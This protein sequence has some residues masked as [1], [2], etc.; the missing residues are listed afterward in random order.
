MAA[1]KSDLLK[2]YRAKY[3]QDDD[4][5]MLDRAYKTNVVL[6][7]NSYPAIRVPDH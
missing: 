1:G 7:E 5:R 2:T 4:L 6:E 3:R